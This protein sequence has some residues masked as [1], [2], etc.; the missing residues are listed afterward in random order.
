MKLPIYAY[1]QSVLKKQ[2]RTIDKEYPGLEELI[3]NMW[4]TMYGA[5]GVGLAAPQIGLPIKL[6]IVDTEQLA[7][8]E[9]E[10][11][12]I[13]QVFINAEIIEETG[14]L[15]DYEEGCLSIPE[16]VGNVSR[17]PNI[18][19]RYLDETFEEKI[20]QFSGIDAR[21]IQHEFDHTR[22]VLFTELLKPVK[23]NLIKRKLENI[24]K[25]KINTEYRMRFVKA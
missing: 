13:K 11:A 16:V 4:D 24:R 17:L 7:E 20:I 6:F 2:C 18:N 9:E 15:W 3:A 10:D 25:G 1:G 22:G 19:L 21:V 5:N 8:K 14:D 23:R 12:G